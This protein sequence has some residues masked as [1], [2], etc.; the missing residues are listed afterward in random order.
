MPESPP[1]RRP[2]YSVAVA[3]DPRLGDDAY[4]L[5]RAAL[6]RLLAR[7][8]PRV[9]VAFLLGDP[10]GRLADRYASERHALKSGVPVG[11]GD[12]AVE[13]LRGMP[14]AVVVFVPGGGGGD[15]E[16]RAE[17]RQLV[18]RPCER[19]VEVRVVAVAPSV[20]DR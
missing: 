13:L 5:V 11:D 17:E 4:P 18:R 1:D 3:G 19:G 8:L 2:F 14:R 7:R 16:L 10:V 6:D 20:P 9:D 15:A 12:P